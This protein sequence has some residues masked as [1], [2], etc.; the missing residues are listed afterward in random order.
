M[1]EKPTLDKYRINDDGD[2]DD[3][4]DDDGDYNDD[5]HHLKRWWPSLL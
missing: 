1:I 2:D 3:D 5:W 4:D